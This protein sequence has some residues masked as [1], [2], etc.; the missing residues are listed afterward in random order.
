MN[1]QNI[2]EY[3]EKNI[4]Y[5]FLTKYY[6]YP[7]IASV[8]GVDKME[9]KHS[10]V[11]KW[12]LEPKKNTNNQGVEYLP[13]K[14]LLKLLQKNNNHYYQFLEIL[15][16]DNSNIQFVKV[17][18][19]KHNIDLLIS[20]K[21]AK[22]EYLIV[23]ENKIESLIRKNQLE[24]YQDKVGQKYSNIPKKIF[25]FLHPGYHININ[26][27]EVVESS[28]YIAITY[29]EI[30]ENI[31][32]EYLEL[33]IDES[34][35]S[36]LNDYIH[37]LSLYSSDE[38]PGG[39]IITTEEQKCLESLFKDQEIINMLNSLSNKKDNNYTD[40][41]KKHKTNFIQL[42]NKYQA[43]NN[44]K[45]EVSSQIEQILKQKSY[46]F[47]QKPYYGIGELLRDIFKKLLKEEKNK[48]TNL[49]DLIYLYSESDPLLV[50]KENLKDVTHRLWYTQNKKIIPYNDKEY[51][52]L[53]AWS[54]KEY[55]ELKERINELKDYNYE[56]YK[57]I[58]IE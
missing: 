14:K 11:L 1:E 26:Q 55:D 50:A 24:D 25:V 48:I 34:I 38:L 49:H 18:R 41:Y 32:K 4:F 51:Y 33:S 10:N 46:S 9:I 40:Y 57:N 6:N 27:K 42:F 2:T 3:M 12:I 53:S 29:Q 47:D 43:M 44:K 16:I 30:Y 13:I 28:K 54:F 19:E 8:Y 23:I 21:I 37:S 22:E 52:V 5:N 36:I 7:N 45:G 39:L 15:D 20:L 17:A 58:T 31:L 56:V 35:K